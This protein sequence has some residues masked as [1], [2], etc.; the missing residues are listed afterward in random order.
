MGGCMPIWLTILIA[1][2]TLWIGFRLNLSD[3]KAKEKDQRKKILLEM[4]D[5]CKKMK[6]HTVAG[7]NIF[8]K[9]LETMPTLTDTHFARLHFARLEVGYLGSFMK[10]H[11]HEFNFKIHNLRQY[12]EKIKDDI[13]INGNTE[14]NSGFLQFNNNDFDWVINLIERYEDL[15]ETALNNDSD[16]CFNPNILRFKMF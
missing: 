10:D 13:W 8:N 16:F 6:T 5:E 15:L 14:N 2:V 7:K 1:L 3:R 9:K 11:R 12:F 4:L